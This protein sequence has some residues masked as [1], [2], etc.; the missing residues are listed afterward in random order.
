MQLLLRQ[1]QPVRPLCSCSCQNYLLAL[2]YLH[3]VRHPS[4]SLVK[5]LQLF[6]ALIACCRTTDLSEVPIFSKSV[7]VSACPHNVGPK[8]TYTR[9]IYGRCTAQIAYQINTSLTCTGV[10][11]FSPLAT[12]RDSDSRPCVRLFSALQKFKCTCVCACQLSSTRSAGVRQLFR[13]RCVFQLSCV[14]DRR[15]L[16]SADRGEP[17]FPRRSTWPR[18]ADGRLPTPVIHSGIHFPAIL[19]YPLSNAISRPSSTPGLPAHTAR[20]TFL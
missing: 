13:S 2:R 15:H 8:L 17:E 16:H 9:P 3:I 4:L 14:R 11:S 5:C 12:V 7:R 10:L 1:H 19:L 6:R 20:W 18:T